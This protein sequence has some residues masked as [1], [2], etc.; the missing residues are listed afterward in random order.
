MQRNLSF[1]K[2]LFDWLLAP[3]RGIIP[4]FSV[5][6]LLAVLLY[7]EGSG[8]RQRIFTLGWAEWVTHCWISHSCLLGTATGC[9]EKLWAQH[10]AIGGLGWVG[11][12]V[13]SYS[14]SQIRPSLTF[15]SA[16]HFLKAMFAGEK[17]CASKKPPTPAIQHLQPDPTGTGGQGC[18]LAPAQ[19]RVCKE[20]LIS[21]VLQEPR[22]AEG[23]QESSPAI[24]LLLLW[25]WKSS[26]FPREWPDL[27]QQ[28]HPV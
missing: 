1:S 19:V 5:Q 23:R 8:K 4:F 6:M 15:A 9:E 7:G 18:A 24:S 3:S 26:G 13:F 22:E 12:K 28:K 20:F 17:T 25:K 14:W 11:F 21:Q 16:A 27:L 10:S 2:Y